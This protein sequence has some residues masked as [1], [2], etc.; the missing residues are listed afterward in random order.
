[1]SFLL[2]FH[3]TNKVHDASEEEEMGEEV[4]VK[5]ELSHV[6]SNEEKLIEDG[7][8]ADAHNKQKNEKAK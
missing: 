5:E 4:K 8:V 1:M 2:Y 3:Q 7:P 6:D